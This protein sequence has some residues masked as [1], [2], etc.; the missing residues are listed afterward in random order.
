MEKLEYLILDEVNGRYQLTVQLT[1]GGGRVE[2][3]KGDGADRVVFQLQTLT[4]FLKKIQR[5]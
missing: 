1:G 2:M 5:V 3:R 4:D